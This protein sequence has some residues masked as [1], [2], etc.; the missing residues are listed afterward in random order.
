MLNSWF[1]EIEFKMDWEA[2]QS[3]PRH[4][5]YRYQYR[6][7]RVSI[8]ARPRYFHATIETDATSLSVI[9]QQNGTINDTVKVVPFSDSQWDELPELFV[10]SLQQM[11]PMFQ[12]DRENSLN[13][14]SA[15]VERTR[16]GKDGAVD[17]DASCVAVD[18]SGRVIG[19]II[20]TDIAAAN[21]AKVEPS[22]LSDEYDTE[23][24]SLMESL[25]LFAGQSHLTWGCVHPYWMRR[26]IGA[27]LLA[28]ACD[29]LKRR[30][31]TTLASTIMYGN[32]PAIL[33]HWRMGF[34]LLSHPESPGRLADG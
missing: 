10:A 24:P 18:E 33:W 1:R 29:D 25:G 28:T 27:E 20:V 3:L 2:F 23:L 5:A 13:L 11:P 26:G 32:E 14:A 6:N 16:L 8:L 31:K 34:S 15:L 21:V 30:G 12:W 17:N 22:I 7:R 9:T 4:P 19:A